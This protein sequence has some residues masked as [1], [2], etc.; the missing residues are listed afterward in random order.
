MR[1]VRFL[2]Y[3]IVVLALL[4]GPLYGA[5]RFILPNWIKNQLASALPPGSQLSIGEMSSTAKMGVKYHNLSFQSAD[6]TINLV[7]EDL[8]VQ[9]NISLSKPAQLLVSKGLIEIGAAKLSITNLKGEMI[10]GTQAEDKIS[11]LGK[12]NEVV[13]EQTV[14]LSNLEFLIKGITSFEKKIKAKATD[15]G[16]NFSGPE[17][18]IFLEL[19]E[20]D[21]EGALNSELTISLQAKRGKIDLSQI[22]RGYPGRIVSGED[23]SVK[24]N[25]NKKGNWELPMQFEAHKLSS[26]SGNLGQFIKVNAKGVWKNTSNQCDLSDLFSTTSFCGK[27]TDVLDILL[28]FNEGEGKLVFSGDGSCVTPNAGCPQVITTVVKTKNTSE[29]LSKVITAGILDPILGGIILGALLSS[30]ASTEDGFDHSAKFDAKGNR[31][32]LN[33]KPII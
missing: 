7:F 28:Q 9:P 11:F 15:V 8:L 14:I 32:F 10:L 13:E 22:G 3:F 2:G 24:T 19:K 30:P 20:T 26:P 1:V 6:K 21:F 18:P 5:G 27:M 4:L 29:M 12:I 23:I 17:G 31:I 25:L 16:L 33:G